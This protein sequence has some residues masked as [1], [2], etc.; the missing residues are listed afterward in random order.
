M[1][2]GLYYPDENISTV[3]DHAFINTTMN[4]SKKDINVLHYRLGHPCNNVL[5]QICRIFPYVHNSCTNICDIFHYSKQH[6]LPFPNST[7]NSDDY[8]DL[9]HVDI[10]GVI[11]ISS[12]HGHK[13]FLTMVDDF[14]RHTWTFLM[15]SKGETRNLLLNF[16]I[17]I[18]NQFKKDIKVI[19]F[20]NGPKF[21]YIDLYNKYGII[22]QRSC[23][24]TPQQNS[25]V[26]RKHQH[27]LN[28]TRSLLFQSN[29]PKCY[30]SYVVNH[31]VHL[32]NIMPSAVLKNKSPYEMLYQKPP[33]YLDLKT[34][35]CLC[36]ASTSDVNISKLDPRARKCVF[37][38]FKNGIK[39]YILLDLKTREIFI[40]RN[41]LFYETIF[42]FSSMDNDTIEKSMTQ[43]LNFLNDSR[44]NIREDHVYLSNPAEENQDDDESIT[45]VDE[46]M[47]IKDSNQGQIEP[48]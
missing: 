11:S 32:I 39:G 17:Y 42:S 5:K 40:S 34:F 30:W 24:G 3:Q 37:I 28:V 10:W 27:V 31:V 43:D 12:I 14:S 36:F 15:H 13:Y 20:D 35:G 8:F 19:R 2:D 41:D 25:I 21:K 23:V 7:T 38:G 6:K 33:T 46:D 1:L 4:Y 26:E 45:D 48:A 29:L 44:I 9:I 16:V 47:V 22:H 18:K